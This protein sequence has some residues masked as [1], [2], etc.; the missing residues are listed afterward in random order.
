ME[1]VNLV[2]IFF[3]HWNLRD[4]SRAFRKSLNLAFFICKMWVTFTSQ[5]CYENEKD[6]GSR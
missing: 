1:V 3:P 2:F 6:E 5:C 4:D